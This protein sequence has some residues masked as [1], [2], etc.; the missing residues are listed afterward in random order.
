MITHAIAE[1]EGME[2]ISDEEFKAEVQYWVD[3][4]YG[5]MTEEEILTNMGEDVIREGTLA[6]KM[7]TWLLGRVTFTFETAE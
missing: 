3:Y 4:Y 2:T 7:Q 1:M 6:E 5:Y